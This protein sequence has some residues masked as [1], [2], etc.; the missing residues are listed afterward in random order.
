MNAPLSLA[1]SLLLAGSAR[2]AQCTPRPFEKGQ[3]VLAKDGRPVVIEKVYADREELRGQVSHSNLLGLDASGKEHTVLTAP[4]QQFFD[5]DQLVPQAVCADGFAEGETV[6][7]AF[8][9]QN[10]YLARI[11]RVFADGSVSVT[12][13]N[14]THAVLKGGFEA[15]GVS[16]KRKSAGGRFAAGETVLMRPRFGLGTATI[17]EA[18][19][20]V[21]D[22]GGAGRALAEEEQLEKIVEEK[23]GVRAGQPVMYDRGDSAV[24]KAVSESGECLLERKASRGSFE[25]S[26]PCSSLRPHPAPAALAVPVW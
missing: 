6:A 24:V 11:E 8:P 1:V 26:R 20:N 17:L 23:A 14:G 3:L 16:V 9:W 13:E 21:Y 7:A 12:L 22:L 15:F 18:Y 2:A 10:Y 25:L 4:R 19:E 5:F